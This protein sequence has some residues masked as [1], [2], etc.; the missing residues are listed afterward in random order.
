MLHTRIGDALMVEYANSAVPRVTDDSV[1]GPNSIQSW[2]Q[3]RFSGGTKLD[4]VVGPNSI[5]SWDQTRFSRGTKLDSV[6]G[7]NSI[8]SWAQCDCFPATPSS[9]AGS[10]RQ[11]LNVPTKAVCKKKT[12]NKI[13]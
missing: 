3:T 11:L 13:K 4:S 1:L 2:D 10:P 12:R 5:Q 7:S 6:L 9:L 8:Q